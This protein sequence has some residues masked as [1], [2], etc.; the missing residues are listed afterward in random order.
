[1]GTIFGNIMLTLACILK[2]S[3][4]K[5]E[6]L[7]ACCTPSGKPQDNMLHPLVP[8]LFLRHISARHYQ[9]TIYTFTDTQ[10][11]C[12]YTDMHVQCPTNQL[13]LQNLEV[14]IYLT[15][16]SWRKFHDTPGSAESPKAAV[17]HPLLQPLVIV[18][19][20]GRVIFWIA[21]VENFILFEI[22]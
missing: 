13:C 2:L 9:N 10:E 18:N 7:E 14:C 16:R 8:S 5:G 1:M 17:I 21:T 12:Y 15:G 6:E 3:D 22:S 19:N 4:L 20:K 11:C